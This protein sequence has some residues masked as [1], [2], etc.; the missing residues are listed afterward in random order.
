MSEFIKKL[1]ES[2]H[3]TEEQI[4]GVE[5]R[6]NSFIK[7][8]QEDPRLR[9]EAQ[10]KLGG[11]LGRVTGAGKRFGSGLAQQLPTA[12]V[13]MSALAIIGG[14]AGVAGDAYRTI[15]DSAG[16]AKAYK[17]M[18]EE[19]GERLEGIPAKQ[20]QQSF[21]TLHSVNPSYAEDPVVAAEFIRETSRSEA[22]PFQLLK[23]VS[24]PDRKK[25]SDLLRRMS[26]VISP[27]KATDKLE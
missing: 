1:A 11:V 13:N 21:N 17:S 15:K 3:L 24:D 25:P 8:A 9:L 26:P 7:A 23:T 5:K 27:M 4:K 12:A 19:A 10:E 16:K 22:Y 18:M 20:I 14:A 2:G 6:V